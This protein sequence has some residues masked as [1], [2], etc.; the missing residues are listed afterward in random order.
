M[1][2]GQIWNSTNIIQCLQNNET[3]YMKRWLETTAVT[4][5]LTDKTKQWNKFGMHPIQLEGKFRWIINK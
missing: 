3:G 4:C 2:A 1:S 5:F